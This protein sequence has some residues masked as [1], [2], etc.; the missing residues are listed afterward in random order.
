MNP[1]LLVVQ[2]V[3]LLGLAVQVLDLVD[4][5]L[6]LLLQVVQL[7]LGDFLKKGQ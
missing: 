6:M 5:V 3:Q 2:L 1:S 7:L 4:E